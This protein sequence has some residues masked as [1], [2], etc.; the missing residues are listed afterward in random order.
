MRFRYFPAVALSLGIIALSACSSA[1]KVPEVDG[2]K[3]PAIA[4]KALSPKTLHIEVK[5]ARKANLEKG[6]A[7]EVEKVVLAALSD[8]AARGGFKLDPASKNKLSV[9][10]E[11]YEQMK[12]DQEECAQFRAVLK[13]K[14][15]SSITVTGRGCQYLEQA[16]GQHIAGEISDA[17]ELGLRK[18]LEILEQKQMA[19]LGHG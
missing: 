1:G 5:C 7:A 18:T 16:S 11:D 10:A 9:T 6:N 12:A 2:S 8:A 14:W 3:L 19:L 13:A 17:F 4:F 15:G